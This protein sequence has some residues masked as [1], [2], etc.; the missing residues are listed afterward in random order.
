M[1]RILLIAT[2]ILAVSV[3]STNCFASDGG[4]STA[5]PSPTVAKSAV[6]TPSATPAPPQQAVAAKPV[7]PAAPKALPQAPVV[8][9]PKG[10]VKHVAPNGA[11]VSKEGTF[12]KM[13]PPR[14][15]SLKHPATRGVPA[16]RAQLHPA[17]KA[18]L[19]AKPVVNKTAVPAKGAVTA[20]PPSQPR[21]KAPAPASRVDVRG[22]RV[23]AHSANKRPLVRRNVH[24]VK[25]APVVRPGVRG[26]PFLP[27][28]PSVRV[29]PVPT[30]AAP[31]VTPI[32]TRR[33][34]PPQPAV[35]QGRG[36]KPAPSKL[37]APKTALKQKPAIKSPPPKQAAV[38]AKKAIARTPSPGA[39]LPKGKPSASA[40]S[41]RDVERCI[42]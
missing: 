30:K 36:V 37:N 2:A 14:A 25:A 39:L 34:M 35:Q 18:L 19:Q 9:S 5:A 41:Q 29:V 12:R 3:F 8:N 38:P 24:P 40:R 7:Q 31:A 1:R 11:A 6:V 17:T 15:F 20:A 22:V 16:S 26:V 21:V 13:V 33:P 10:R 4:Q 42:N 23:R 28:K 32:R 27:P